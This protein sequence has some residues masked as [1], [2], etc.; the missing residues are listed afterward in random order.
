MAQKRPAL[1]DDSN[2]KSPEEK[3]QR[4]SLQSV[5]L[6]AVKR[7]SMQKLWIVLEPLV[8]RVVREEVERAM[9]KSFSSKLGLRLPPKQ[10]EGADS[11]LR[12]QFQ[13]S[14]SLPIFTGSKVE[15]EQGNIRVALLDATTGLVV[16]V[17]EVAS[18]KLDIV[19]LEGDFAHDDDEDWSLE[20]FRNHE[21]K[22]REGKRPLLTGDLTVSLKDGV[23]ILGEL[24]F[25]DNSS[26]IR[27]RKF[28][29]GVKISAGCLNGLHVREAKTQAF[30]V[31]DHRGQLYK[32]HYPPALSD[33]VWRL[34]KIGK[35]GAYHKRLIEN[36]IKTVEDFLVMYSTG[37]VKLREI[38]GN[39]MSAKTWDSIIEHAKTC[40]LNETQRVYYPDDSHTI[41]V[42]LNA[43][44]QPL[45][46]LR[47]GSYV[48]SSSLSEAEQ[49]HMDRLVQE[50]YNDLSCVYKY[51]SKRV[52]QEP[53]GVNPLSNFKT[54]GSQNERVEK[55]YLAGG[56]AGLMC[57]ERSQKTTAWQREQF[58]QLHEQTL[59]R[60][61]PEVVPP[62]FPISANYPFNVIQKESLSPTMGIGVQQSL[63]NAFS[64]DSFERTI[65][66][67]HYQQ[68][69]DFVHTGQDNLFNHLTTDYGYLG[70]NEVHLPASVNPGDQ[71]LGF[72]VSSAMQ[73]DIGFPLAHV[74]ISQN[75]SHRRGSLSRRAYIGWIKLK[76]ALK[77]T[78]TKKR[79]NSSQRVQIYE[80]DD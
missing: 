36:Q 27:S 26:W 12:L 68:Q 53:E 40:S 71:S 79:V 70:N 41:G 8:R 20:D 4:T 60:N 54:S 67:G 75:Y 77:W 46:I 66:Y 10:L 50:A 47:N 2:D 42:I 35:D 44:Y 21:V 64:P 76:A 28:R 34:E 58:Q 51:Q 22:E 33:D 23:G 9:S 7:N 16:S 74:P 18:A 25:T 73:G 61:L 19:V 72:L 24:V 1:N 6:E 63:L 13:N 43:I 52:F 45:G 78:F 56:Y 5:V 30:Y 69:R 49:V 80:L 31:K 29:L 3:R 65:G 55:S 38:F 59:T 32:K 39:T 48:Q 17:G 62:S 15:G 37:P 14:L 57:D 11:R